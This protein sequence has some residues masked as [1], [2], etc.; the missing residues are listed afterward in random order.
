VR[1]KIIIILTV[2][3]FSGSPMGAALG[4]MV[5]PLQ[6]VPPVI[7]VQPTWRSISG[8]PGVEYVPAFR[9]DLFRYQ[10]N[11]YCWHDGH[12]FLGQSYRGPWTRIQSPP[13][14]FRQIAPNYWKN[15][16]G[17]A[18]GKKTGW[19]GQPL[20]PGQMK[21]LHQAAGPATVPYGG[22]QLGPTVQPAPVVA[23]VE[24]KGP[25]KGKKGGSKGKMKHQGRAGE[26]VPVDLGGHGG[27]PGKGWG[28][29]K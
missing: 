15:P 24:N 9:Q 11:Y 17:W 4:Q 14:V 26:A 1:K 18:H 16:A 5:V 23:A 12:W 21:R 22:S 6:G 7:Q 8:V 28:K 10:N 3:L 20:P 13:P 19:R 27:P 29:F 2:G 25:S